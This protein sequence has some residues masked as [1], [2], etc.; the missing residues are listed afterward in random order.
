[1]R[2]LLAWLQRLLS[3]DVKCPDCRGQ[4]SR[5]VRTPGAGFDRRQVAPCR[6]CRGTGRITD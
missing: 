5:V 1:M 2:R 6:L 4:G 3:E